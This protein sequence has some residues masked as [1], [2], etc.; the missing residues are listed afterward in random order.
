MIALIVFALFFIGLMT[1][2]IIRISISCLFWASKNPK[3]KQSVFKACFP[4][5]I[6][7]LFA[8]CLAFIIKFDK[9]EI[10]V[11]YFSIVYFLTL[12][13]WRSELKS[14]P[15]KNKSFAVEPNHPKLP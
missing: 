7:I 13:I 3:D 10:V 2:V 1:F 4:Y 11:Y 12:F 6:I 14:S 8:I 5:Y 9:N 15:K